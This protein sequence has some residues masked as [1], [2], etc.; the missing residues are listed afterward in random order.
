MNTT[1]P[2]AFVT[3]AKAAAREERIAKAVLRYEEQRYRLEQDLET[4]A[5]TLESHEV[6]AVKAEYRADN[7][8]TDSPF[9]DELV[10]AATQARERAES[11]KESTTKA[12]ENVQKAIDELNDKITKVIN[13]ETKVDYAEV[14]TRARE[15]LQGRYTEVYNAGVFDAPLGKNNS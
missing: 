5:K 1:N 11:L 6:P 14:I 7:E 8:P 12:M 10:E 3:A 15:L 4:Y 9:K 2:Q 13:G